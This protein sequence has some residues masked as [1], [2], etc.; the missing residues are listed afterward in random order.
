MSKEECFSISR[1]PVYRR[2][3]AVRQ[4]SLLHHSKFGVRYSAVLFRVYGM[5]R[6]IDVF[7]L[8]PDKVL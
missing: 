1:C 4:L 8:Q 6:S 5:R 3:K 7:R 2:K